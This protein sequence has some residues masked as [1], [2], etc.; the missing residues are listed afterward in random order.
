V[1]RSFGISGNLFSGKIYSPVAERR[2]EVKA[3]MNT[4]VDD[5][6]PV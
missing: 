3:T 5:V 2:N 4:I 6:L 1:E